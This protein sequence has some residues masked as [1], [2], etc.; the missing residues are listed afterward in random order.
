MNKK[1][2]ALTHALAILFT[3]FA[4]S[5]CSSDNS[6]GAN[7]NEGVFANNGKSPLILDSISSCIIN[8]DSIEGLIALNKI[9]L[10][11]FDGTWRLTFPANIND[12]RDNYTIATR[13]A[14]DTLIVS[15][16]RKK[17]AQPYPTSPAPF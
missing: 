17:K 7:G 3:S 6:S 1:S 5:G 11:Y 13:S 8:P 9:Y 12:L 2:I 15:M 10:K 4:I 14:N 16:K